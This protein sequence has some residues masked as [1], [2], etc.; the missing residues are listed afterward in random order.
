MPPSVWYSGLVK[1]QLLAH[2]VYDNWG[3]VW[4]LTQG[5]VFKKQL[6]PFFWPC[7]MALRSS[8]FAIS[9]TQL[10]KPYSSPPT[11]E[12]MAEMSLEFLLPS[13][14]EVQITVPTAFF[15]IA[16]YYF[17]IGFASSSGDRAEE[18]LGALD[19]DDKEKVNINAPFLL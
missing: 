9:P 17:L 12:A 1:K 3:G 7:A 2:V 18:E 6:L 13:W 8:P 15:V 10:Y 19:L 14:R 16:V 5:C 4:R 11:S